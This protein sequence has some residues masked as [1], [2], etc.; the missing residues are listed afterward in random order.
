MAAAAA[1]HDMPQP[2]GG[3]GKN[4]ARLTSGLLSL[5]LSVRPAVVDGRLRGHDEK[6]EFD[7][8]ADDSSGLLN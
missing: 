3:N 8:L 5:A 2:Y 4:S 7:L 1:I 6:G